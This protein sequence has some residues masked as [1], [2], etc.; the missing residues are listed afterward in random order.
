MKTRVRRVA[1]CGLRVAGQ[2]DGLDHL[3]DAKAAD[4]VRHDKAV[5][6][7]SVGA[8]LAAAKDL[9]KRRCWDYSNPEQRWC[10]GRLAALARRIDREK[11]QGKS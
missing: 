6:S 3:A 2:K 4:Q 5:A 7:L 8:V 11:L 1:G 10:L 9:G